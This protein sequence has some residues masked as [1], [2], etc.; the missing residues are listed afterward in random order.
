MP[1]WRRL[2]VSF[3]AFA[4]SRAAAKAGI[5]TA[6][7]MKM[8]AIVT[9]NSIRVKARLKRLGELLAIDLV[10]R[11]ARYCASVASESKKGV[12]RRKFACGRIR[13]VAELLDK[14]L[15]L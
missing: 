13:P 6:A 14:V 2:L 7:R 3:V 8:I 4:R 11:R 10:V 15:P 5:A 1:I 9:S 12:S